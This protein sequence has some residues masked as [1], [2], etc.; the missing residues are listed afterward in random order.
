MTIKPR[1][2]WYNGIRMRSASEAYF[3]GHLDRQNV[4]WTYET[5]GYADKNGHHLPDFHLTDA[6]EFVA[7]KHAD[8]PDTALRQL[9][10]DL[11]VIWSTDP[12]AH[13]TII[14]VEWSDTA[15][16]YVGL[17]LY[18][19]QV[20]LAVGQELDVMQA[21]TL[22]GSQWTGASLWCP[23]CGQDAIGGY[24]HIVKVDTEPA[25]LRDECDLALHVQCE[26]GH[27]FAICFTQHKGSTKVKCVFEGPS[28]FCCEPDVGTP[29]SESVIAITTRTR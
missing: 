10:R 13:L 26:N 4:A 25:W 27:A 20:P 6:N 3:A 23:I 7:I 8:F 14:Q 28:S 5:A 22:D 2:T 29:A 18:S 19:E 21:F 12:T 1:P 9:E 17:H 16:A 11:R 15:H 24:T